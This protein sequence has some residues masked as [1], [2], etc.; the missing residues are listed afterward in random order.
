MGQVYPKIVECDRPRH[1]VYVLTDLSR[2]SWNPEQPA[3]GLDKVTKA[4]AAPGGKVATFIVRL[5]S[6]DIND[7]AID[8]AT[9]AKNLI[10]EGES[11]EVKG[12]IHAKGEKAASRVVEFYLDGVKKGE[13]PVELPPGGQLEVSFATPPRLPEG[14]LHRGELRLGGTPDPL[15]FN[16][17]RYFT[18]KV[19]P[20]YKVLLIADQSIDAD[21]VALA[22][23]PEATPS[24]SS[25]FQIDRVRSKDLL[26]QYRDSLKDYA[27]VFVLN[28]EGFEDEETWGILNGYVHE[29]G[30]LVFGLGDRCNPENYNG[31]T[32]SQLLPAQLDPSRPTKGETTFG[33]IEDATHPLFQRY[34]KE[35]GTQLALVPVYR[36]WVVTPPE[37]SRVLLNYADGAPA[38]LERTFKGSKT[39]RVLLWTTPLSRRQRRS[40]RGAWNEFPLPTYW[41]YFALMNETVPYLAGTSNEQ[42]NFEAGENVMLF[43]GTGA[44]PGLS[45]HGARHQEP[46]D[47]DTL[48]H[49]RLPRDHCSPDARPV[50]RHGEGCRQPADTPR[51]QPQ[52][53]SR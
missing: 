38:L 31:P 37:G 32:A 25:G 13:K 28:V 47:A 2:S 6:P 40:E 10:T 41:A 50:D 19:R 11:V 44:V 30:G 15:E 12:Q 49:E 51:L 8:A 9:P 14:E 16:D 20:A 1:E 5:G 21:F 23:D 26:A 4:K 24:A 53:A 22:L 3:E 39:G 17:K 36:Y 35:I 18:F 45:T 34:A 46:G 7:V 33:K 43:L 27:A 42:L 48:G 52:S 29:G